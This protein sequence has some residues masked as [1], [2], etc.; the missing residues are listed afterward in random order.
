[1]CIRSAPM[2]VRICCMPLHIVFTGMKAL[3]CAGMHLGVA[4]FRKNTKAT[5]HLADTNDTNTRKILDPREKHPHQRRSC[6]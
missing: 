5:C 1:M 2:Q 4:P 6:G 3:A